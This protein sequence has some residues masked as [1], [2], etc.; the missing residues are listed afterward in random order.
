MKTSPSARKEFRSIRWRVLFYMAWRNLIS[1][2]LRSLLT[3]TGVVIGIGSIFFLLSFGIGV[4]DLVTKEIIGNQSIK[5]VDV[6]SS[7]SRIVKLDAA[8]VEKMSK[9]PHVENVGLLYSYAGSLG[10]SGAS[11]DT[12]TYGVN[13]TYQDMV[14]LTVVAGRT[15]KN[16]DNKSI[17]LNKSAAESVGLTDYKKAIGQTIDLLVPL[18]GVGAKSETLTDQY[19]IVGIVETV[20]GNEIYIPSFHFDLVGVPVFSQVRLLVDYT[21]NIPDLRKQVEALGYETSS[22]SD[23]IEQVNQIFTFFNFMLVGF[24][25]I[26]MI[27]AVL[28]MFNTLTISLLERTKEIGLMIS[29][30]GRNIDMSKLFIIEAFILSIVGALVGIFIAV[31]VGQI[32]NALMLAFALGRGVENG[33][34]LFAVPW[35]L[36]LG[37]VGFMALVGLLVALLPAWRAQKIDPID[38]LRRE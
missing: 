22:P 20:P 19:Q 16:D 33:F 14:D 36:V 27:V 30:G 17:V 24:G 31:I 5:T 29:L 21:D 26:S 12:I 37:L 11:V 15:L 8:N 7:N 28:G 4:Q 23:T 2:K 38:A 32:V 6:T 35:W 10:R 1:K 13:D 34:Q 25:S 18:Q 3:I 9:M